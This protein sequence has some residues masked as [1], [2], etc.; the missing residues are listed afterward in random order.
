MDQAAWQALTLLDRTSGPA[1]MTRPQQVAQ[2]IRELIDCGSLA[3]GER[4][5]PE[6]L[7]A[8]LLGV[9]RLSLREGLR[10]LEALDLV[11]VRRGSGVYVESA[12]EQE[13][14]PPLEFSPPR[15]RD[16]E[17]FFEV[18]R[19]LEP[20][21]AELAARRADPASLT[22]LHLVLEEFNSTASAPRRRFDVLA[23]LDIRLHE[24][25]ILCA[26]N[27]LLAHLLR[28]LHGLHRL[29][30]EWSLRRP[31]RLEET[32][33]EH[34]RLVDAIASHDSLSARE[35]ML[36][37]LAAAAAAFHAVTGGDAL[38]LD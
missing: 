10:R 6:R 2:H 35:T 16:V 13:R 8:Q 3:P 21:A 25:I 30:L 4:L 37:H 31:R 1:P 26:E 34:R 38:P 19:L 27:A 23:D 11:V 5:P 28:H 36:V 33:A 7:L 12:R 22:T 9:S 18:R 32:S 15:L 17:E 20:A 14:T 24:E 29:Q